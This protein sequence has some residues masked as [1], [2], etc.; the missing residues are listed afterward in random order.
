M[1]VCPVIVQEVS[2]SFTGLVSFAPQALCLDDVVMAW[3]A[4]VFGINSTG[5]ARNR[6][7]SYNNH[8]GHLQAPIQKGPISP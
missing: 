7:M 1:L 6:C 3:S 8:M 2:L 5:K 4:V